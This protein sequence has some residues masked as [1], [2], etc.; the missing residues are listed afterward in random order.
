MAER[1]SYDLN[2]ELLSGGIPDIAPDRVR[3]RASELKRMHERATAAGKEIEFYEDMALLT[4]TLSYRAGHDPLTGLLNRFLFDYELDR[5]WRIITREGANRNF[6]L[7][8]L[9]LNKF[10]EVNDTF[11]HPVGDSMLQAVGMRLKT[12]FRPADTVC[13][14]GGDE[15]AVIAD[16]TAVQ[17]RHDEPS[18]PVDPLFIARRIVESIQSTHLYLP[19]GAEIGVG[20]SV[21]VALG[22]G[23]GIRSS[24]DWYIAA[25]T[26]MYKAKNNRGPLSSICIRN[27]D[28]SSSLYQL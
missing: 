5:T 19:S 6:C 2:I 14:L 20:T 24:S 8:F 26:A 4:E 11:G 12:A 23:V 16:L 9:D 17:T 25:D 22:V 7:F 13:R 21:G 27:L 18:E 15:F 3:E 10:K 1:E 28:G